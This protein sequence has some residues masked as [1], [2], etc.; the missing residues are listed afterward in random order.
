MPFFSM[1]EKNI[2]GNDFLREKKRSSTTGH[3]VTSISHSRS[4]MDLTST[5]ESSVLTIDDFD[6][7]IS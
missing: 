5:T 4:D 6:E 2:E 7:T 1:T 3:V